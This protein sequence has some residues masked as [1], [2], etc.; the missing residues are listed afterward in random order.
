MHIL[1]AED[2]PT[3]AHHIRQVLEEAS[4][5]V[6]LT[7]RGD[8]ALEAAR[9]EGFDL[10]VSDVVMPGM[11]GYELCHALK[12][13][14]ELAKTPILLLTS[15]DEPTDVL[16]GLEAGADSYLTKPFDPAD[17]L[18]RIDQLMARGVRVQRELSTAVT[19]SFQGKDVQ[20]TFDGSQLVDFFLTSFEDYI[21]A[22]ARQAAESRAKEDVAAA[23]A[24]VEST[25]DALQIQVAI[26]DAE[27]RIVTANVAW[28][29]GNEES[30]PQWL[31]GGN[32]LEALAAADSEET[33]RLCAGLEAMIAG[34]HDDDGLSYRR[35]PCDAA[36][37]R[38][39]NVSVSRFQL[40]G[41]PRLVIAH[42]DVTEETLHAKRR[43]ARLEVARALGEAEALDEAAPSI[44]RAMV[45]VAGF[46]GAEI[47]RC[48]R[49]RASLVASHA[50]STDAELRA[51]FEASRDV[52]F[53]PGEGV[54]GRAWSERKLLWTPD[55]QDDASFVRSRHAREAGIRASIAVPVETDNGVA[56]VLHVVDHRERPGDEAL[57]N[58]LRDIATQ[59]GVF[60]ERGEARA[61][62]EQRAAE[63]A[64]LEARQREQAHFLRAVLESVAD[65]V[66]VANRAG[67]LVFFNAALERTLG[68]G[69]IADGPE[70]WSERYGLFSA[71]GQRK[72][73]TAELPLV[74]ALSGE[75]VHA[76]LLVRNAQRPRGVPIHVTAAPILDD[77]ELLGAVAVT[78]D[79]TAERAAQKALAE[80]EDELRHA[81]RL[82]AVGRLAGGIAHDFNNLLTVIISFGSFVMEALEPES[83]AADDMKEVLD[84]GRRAES[85]TRQLLA[86]S[87]RGSVEPRVLNIN[88][89]VTEIDKM[90]RRL[91]GEDIAFATVL[92]ER[93]WNVTI[94]P[95]ALEQVVVNLAV[96][97]R[98]AMPHGGKLTIETRNVEVDEVT[99]AAKGRDM[100]VGDY[101]MVALTDSGEGIPPEHRDKIFEPFFT[102][103]PQGRGT[104]LGLSTCY[105]IV[106]QAEGYI[107]V[108]SELGRGTTFKIYLPRASTETSPTVR[109]S[110][111]TRKTGRDRVVLLAED[112][113]SVRQAT[114]RALQRAGY[115]VLEADSGEAALALIEERS[116]RIDLLITDVV[117][118]GMTG[119]ELAA[120]VCAR[121]PELPVLYT[122][123][124][125]E[126][127]IAHHGVLENGIALLPKPYAP[128]A[129]ID[130]V[131]TILGG[132]T[133]EEEP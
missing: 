89:V 130:K 94:D 16:R 22:R 28:K 68:M 7:M 80:K 108:Y 72:V 121:H 95:G 1:V 101:V 66:A 45:R 92:D 24:F 39:C 129:L 40:A 21:R 128:Q 75:V 85:L 27:G 4:H 115:A 116:E 52:T 91:L 30:G 2:S 83:P 133:D 79:L 37:T 13:D 32:Y 82:D 74:R 102:T 56:A 93:L 63:L 109:T 98:D 127:A 122:S 70:A 25:F 46:A 47:W 20:L 34:A 26:V 8:E 106:K 103:K 14:P 49:D 131:G 84:A 9:A 132:D 96:N 43:Q 113:P 53:A 42:D 62:L 59:I 71:D 54:P 58:A 65:G 51:F 120:A 126:N 125:T 105:G 104:G 112:D 18:A 41:E 10:V 11:S 90:L 117:M 99:A 38:Y 97:A 19:A 33:R 86:F 48:E 55:V 73:E 88:G 3:Q 61:A 31:P 124:Y 6:H 69:V 35:V 67:E 23:L 5:R 15:L 81:Q 87:R 17:L 107:W 60:V 77:G 100:P 111:P 29:E 44:L 36:G 57:A 114:A 76:E 119:R 12:A 78:R 123:G 64:E 110:L 50:P 118:P